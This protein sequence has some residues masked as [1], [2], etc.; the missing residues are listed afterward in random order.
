MTLAFGQIFCRGTLP[1]TAA[2]AFERLLGREGFVLFDPKQ[3]PPR[4]PALPREFVRTAQAVG[5]DA[6][7]VTLLADDWPRTFART[8]GLSKELPAA[9][10]VALVHPPLENTRAK[11]Y[12]DGEL[13]LKVG[14]DPDDELFFNPAISEREALDAF[15][16]AWKNA[17]WPGR[18]GGPATIDELLSVLAVARTDAVFAQAVG[19]GWPVPVQ[20]R[21]FISRHSRLYLAS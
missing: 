5:D 8:L 20:T 1:D 12:R 13:V 16:T 14:D 10:V 19:G 4:Y 9:T 2:A 18:G 7:T 15:A 21:L 3:V 11:A 17:T 6:G